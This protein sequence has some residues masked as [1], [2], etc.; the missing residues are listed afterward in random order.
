MTKPTV[1]IE[2]SLDALTERVA[3]EFS[4]QAAQALSS[5]KHFTCV[6]SGGSTPVALYA[7]LAQT[8]RYRNGIDWKRVHFFWGDERH[9]GPD[10]R[11]SNYRIAKEAMLS[12]LEIPSGNVHRILGELTSAEDAA[13]AY[14]EELGRFFGLK[15][16]ALPRFDFVLLGM[17]ADGHTAS[18]F[19]GIPQLD[20]TRRR[21]L[22]PWVE[23]LAEFR[24]TLS[25]LTFNAAA[26][27]LF[28]VAGREKAPTLKAV[29][30]GPRAPNELPCQLIQPD[31]GE[32]VWALDQA[33]A[34]QLKTC[35]LHQ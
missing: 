16:G 7:L 18:L 13:V 25:P 34:S 26:C 11:E 14:D 4:K 10:A 27:V 30:E 32:L 33:A 23:K 5:R 2:E 21:V 17:G 8:A 22:A 28:L 29:L 6:L 12:P 15:P 20:D 19:P 1:I 24:V 35:P 31:R 9:A 3:E